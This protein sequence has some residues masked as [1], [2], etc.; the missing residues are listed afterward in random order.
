MKKRAITTAVAL[1]L[2]GSTTTAMA[3]STLGG[4]VF[5]DTYVQD[6]DSDLS[7]TGTSLTRTKVELPSMSRLRGKW[8]NEDDVTM[9]IEWGFGGRSASS[10]T[11]LRHAWGKWDFSRTGQLMAGHSS[12][13]F[14]P[15]FPSQTIGN[16]A[17]ES[18][19][20]GK[21]YGE[22]SSGRAP[23]VRYTYKFLNQRGALAIAILDPNRDDNIDS[24]I[25][26]EKS[27]TIPR[28]DIGMAYRAYNWQIFPSVFFQESEYE[29]PVTDDDNITSWGA[30]LGVKGGSGPW[31]LSAEFNIGENMRNA[32]LSMGSSVAS[33]AGGAYLY[34]DENGVTQIGDTENMSGWVDLGYKFQTGELKGTVHFVAGMMESERSDSGDPTIDLTYESTMVGVSVPIDLPWIAKG[35]RFRP[36]IFWYDNDNDNGQDIDGVFQKNGEEILGGIQLQYTF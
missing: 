21:G 12:S 28:I 18:H 23:Q 31:V 32:N 3:K 27:A 8:T 2:A 20:V 10:G 14:S 19:N 4:I 29:Q 17:S 36:E 9:Y 35:F 16:N 7:P 24:E 33:Q 30:S 22:I 1:V 11:S 15:L 25:G 6:F 13:P 26:G 5:V 34:Q